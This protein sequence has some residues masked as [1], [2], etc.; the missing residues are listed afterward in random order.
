MSAHTPGPWI[1]GDSD[2]H[3]KRDIRTKDLRSIAFCGS[4]PV[5]E[6]HANA[7]LIAAAPELLEA[8]VALT[9]L[10]DTDEGCRSILEYQNA[11]A[12]I[13]KATGEEVRA[14]ARYDQAGAAVAELVEAVKLDAVDKAIASGLGASEWRAFLSPREAAALACVGGA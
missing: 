11:N 7:R 2:D 6:A 4:Y 5:E 12:A 3:W 10:Y 13:A 8:L 9:A 1:Q 14:K